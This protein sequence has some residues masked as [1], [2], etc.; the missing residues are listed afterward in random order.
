METI[1]QQRMTAYTDEEFVVFLIGMRLNKLWKFHKWVPVVMAMGRMISELMTE[2]NSDLLHIESWGGRT[3]IMV[4]YWRSFDALEAY[5]KN[6]SRSHLPA[7]SHFNKMTKGNN[8]IGIWHETYLVKPESFECIY[9]NMPKF[10]LAKA[11]SIVPATGGWKNAR[12]R[13]TKAG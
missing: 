10:G 4:Q 2:E 5:A 1:V 12:D 8:D 11:T 9:N 13:L 6:D 7:W 3:T